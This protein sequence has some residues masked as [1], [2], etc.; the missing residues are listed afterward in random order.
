MNVLALKWQMSRW[1]MCSVVCV[2]CYTDVFSAYTKNKSEA[3]KVENSLYDFLRDKLKLP[4]NRSN[5]GIRKPV[6][7]QVL[8]FGFEPTCT[9]GEKGAYQQDV[10]NKGWHRLKE[11]PENDYKKNITNEFYGALPEAK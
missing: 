10:G 2:C 8:G 7:F 1:G 6:Q 11:T 3:R 9:R 5:N 4:I